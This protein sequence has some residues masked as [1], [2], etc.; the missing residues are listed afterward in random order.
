LNPRSLNAWRRNAV[1]DAGGFAASTLAPDADLIATLLDH[2]WLATH[3]DRAEAGV[4]KPS[5]LRAMLRQRVQSSFG[6]LQVLWRHRPWS[7]QTK[8]GRQDQLARRKR[9]YRRWLA[10]L[11]ADVLTPVAALPAFGAAALSVL[12]GNFRPILQMGLF[13][14]AVELVQLIVASLLA[15]QRTIFSTMRLLPSFIVS[16]LIYRPVR[17]AIA[18]RSLGR[19][20][21]GIPIEWT[22]SQRKAA[23]AYAA[24][25]RA[26]ARR[27]AR[28]FWRANERS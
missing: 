10:L 28:S 15:S 12:A 20:I 3:A 13:L 16:Q 6:V 25:T 24:A 7:A 2:G 23:V 9:S 17:W 5:T 26:F 27:S 8:L 4:G 14:V 1:L 18:L 22:S 11:M 19:L 21:D